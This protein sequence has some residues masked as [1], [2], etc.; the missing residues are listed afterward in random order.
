MFSNK[1]MRHKKLDL[2]LFWVNFCPYYS[3][4]FLFVKAGFK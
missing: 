1:Y 2:F 3:G 4:S